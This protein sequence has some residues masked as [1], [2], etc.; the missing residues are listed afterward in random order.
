MRLPFRTPFQ[1]SF[2]EPNRADLTASSVAHPSEQEA[3]LPYEYQLDG[4]GVQDSVGGDQVLLQVVS[5]EVPGRRRTLGA[6][7]STQARAIWAGVAP[8]YVRQFGPPEN[9]HAHERPPKAGEVGG[10]LRPRLGPAS[11]HREE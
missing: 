9:A 11:R 4:R 1:V 7:W 10:G 5:G 2:T 3:A 6:R 8:E